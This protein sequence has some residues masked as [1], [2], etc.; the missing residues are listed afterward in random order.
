MEIS[1]QEWVRLAVA[2]DQRFVVFKCLQ[3]L[4]DGM[5]RWPVPCHLA[6]AARN[7]ELFGMLGNRGI[8]AIEEQAQ[9]RFLLPAFAG[10]GRAARGADGLVGDG[11]LDARFGHGDLAM[12]LP[13][14]TRRSS[15]RIS[16]RQLAVNCLAIVKVFGIESFASDFTRSSNHKGIINAIAVRLRNPERCSMRFACDRER[17]RPDISKG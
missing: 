12:I 6:D 3:R 8:D 13:R 7:Y 17:T 11:G 9:R 14:R 5:E 4:H 16:N 1:F 15:K 10:K 2:D